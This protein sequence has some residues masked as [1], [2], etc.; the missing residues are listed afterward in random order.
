[1]PSTVERLA[2]DGSVAIGNTPEEFAA[3]IKGEHVKWSRVVREANIRV[4]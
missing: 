3:F 1:M 4:E 2:F